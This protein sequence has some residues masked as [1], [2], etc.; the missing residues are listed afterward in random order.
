MEASTDLIYKFQQLKWQLKQIPNWKIW[1]MFV[2]VT[3]CVFKTKRKYRE[4]TN[5]QKS[6]LKQR[7]GLN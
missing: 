7:V 3:F 5:G 1:K 6:N 4:K 2:P